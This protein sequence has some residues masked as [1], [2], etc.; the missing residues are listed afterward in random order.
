M[1]QRPGG[2][3]VRLV[4]A[5]DSTRLNMNSGSVS[6]AITPHSHTI[7]VD[8]IQVSIPVITRPSVSQVVMI[9]PTNVVTSAT[10]PLSA[11]TY[12]NDSLNSSGA[13]MNF[14]TV[15]ILT[16]TKKP[17]VVSWKPGNIQA[18]INRPIA[19]AI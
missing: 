1:F 18:A 16:T 4:A 3:V 15:K 11:R 19:L 5:L 8:R 14:A 10:P 2:S 6:A 17:N 9:R 13:M 7:S 12:L